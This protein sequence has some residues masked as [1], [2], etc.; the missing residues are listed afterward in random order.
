MKI[1]PRKIFFLLSCTIVFFSHSL[2]ANTD[3]ST[4]CDVHE[5]KKTA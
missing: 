2:F 5:I 4:T 1:T 3:E